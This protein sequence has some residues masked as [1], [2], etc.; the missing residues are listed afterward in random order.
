LFGDFHDFGPNQERKDEF[1]FF[2]KTATSILVQ[3]ELKFVHDIGAPLIV[4]L[5]EGFLNRLNCSEE[6]INVVLE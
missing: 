2:Q 5:G 3:K 6:D 1:V 4:L